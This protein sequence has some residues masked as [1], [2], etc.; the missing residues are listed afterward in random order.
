MNKQP[1]VSVIIPV[2]N[3]S[4]YIRCCLNS[5]CNQSYQ[6][7]EI[8]LVDD[9]STDDS[10]DICDE[11]SQVD[12]RVLVIHKENGGL[13]DARNVGISIFHGEYLTF[14]DSDDF[15][16]Q[17]YIQCLLHLLTKYGADISVINHQKFFDIKK[18]KKNKKAPYVKC[19]TGITA[20]A[21]MWYKR[22]I[23]NSAW[24]KLYKK[25]LFQNVR[26]PIGKLYEDLG[27]TYKLFYL[28]NKV[29]Y[30]S[31]VLYFYFQR[32]N[33]VMNRGFAVEKMDRIILSEELLDWSKQ[34]CQELEKA[35]VARVFLSNL[36]VLREISD[37][38]K[39]KKQY[40]YI[41]NNIKKYR[42]RVMHD[43]DMKF[44]YRVM[45]WCCVFEGSFL[46]KMEL[47]YK[48]IKGK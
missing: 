36:Q 2:Y 31:E 15:V 6:N 38:E 47:I 10:G 12:N 48:Q 41:N 19:F 4:S 42:V 30:S 43:K 29:V 37:I 23:S 7:L 24:G 26:Y 3:V 1:L 32:S 13:S 22:N 45:A 21:D 17:E 27:T 35:A 44:I 5:V 33:S 20:I 46:K 8:I 39:Y 9:G 18:I 16:D 25:H 14:I 28:S 40:Q 11:Y 34:Y